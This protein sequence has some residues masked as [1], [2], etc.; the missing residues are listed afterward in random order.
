M[1]RIDIGKPIE[2][3]CRGHAAHSA[4]SDIDGFVYTSGTNASGELGNGNNTNSSSYMKI[5]STIVTTDKDIYYLDINETSE[6]IPK[7]INTFNLKVDIVDDNKQ[8]FTISIPDS[9]KLNLSDY[10][11]VTALDYGLNNCTVTH[12]GTGKTKDIVIK[13][14]KKMNDIIQGIRDS[15]LTDGIYEILVQG[16]IYKI[17]IYNYYND[18]KYSL[19]SGEETKTVELGNDTADETMLVVK[20]HGDL[21]IDK[22]VTLTAKTRK[23]GMYV[24][25]LGDT[26]NNGEITM[27]KKRSKCR[28][29]ARCILMGKYR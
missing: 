20:Y 19:D 5:G 1:T 8:N 14:V 11:Q 6:V 29:R 23:K 17:E 10:N 25:V 27:T 22:G 12:T 16:E 4:I 3:I 24:C 9:T 7:L 2:A 28:R 15:S 13:T 21:E 26:I 18:M